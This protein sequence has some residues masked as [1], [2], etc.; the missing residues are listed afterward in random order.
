MAE[1]ILLI[2]APGA[3]KSSV[4]EALGNQLEVAAVPFGSLESEQLSMGW[5]LVPAA[6]WVPLLE[7]VVE[8][9]LRGGRRWLIVAATPESSH[10]LEAMLRAFGSTSVFVVALI[11]SP[12]TAARRVGRREPDRWPGKAQLVSHARDLAATIATFERIDLRVDTEDTDPEDVA[13]RILGATQSA[14]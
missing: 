8:W 10:E 7:T 5:P 6:E 9:H 14:A 12:D 1:A 11:A 4:L 13:R 2:G 3:G